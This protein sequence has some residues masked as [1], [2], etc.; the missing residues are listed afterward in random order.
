MIAVR[1]IAI[2][3]LFFEIKVLECFISHP[4]EF[5]LAY[6]GIPDMAATEEWNALKSF[7]FIN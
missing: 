3:V 7:D 2:T 5:R 6:W 1:N 4:K